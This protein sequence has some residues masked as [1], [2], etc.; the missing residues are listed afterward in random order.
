M[1][2]NRSG[3]KQRPTYRAG[4]LHR[5]IPP[6]QLPLNLPTALKSRVSNIAQNALRAY[7]IGT[8]DFC[9]ALVRNI[10]GLLLKQHCMHTLHGV[11]SKQAS[12]AC[13]RCAGPDPQHGAKP[14]RRL[15]SRIS[16]A[17]LNDQIVGRRSYLEP[18]PLPARERRF[19]RAQGMP[20][21]RPALRRCNGCTRNTNHSQQKMKN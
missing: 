6:A 8:K 2:V 17:D 19:P 15:R 11:A 9:K 12:S 20:T 14:C 7:Q 4:T 1:F 21:H 5:S 3:T 13:R 16:R 18:L 10:A